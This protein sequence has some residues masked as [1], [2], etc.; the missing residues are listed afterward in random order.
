MRDCGNQD[1]RYQWIKVHGIKSNLFL[2]SSGVLQSGYMSP[3][4]YSLLVNG[5]GHALHNSKLFCFADDLKLFTQIDI[6]R[7]IVLSSRTT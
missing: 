6:H 3:I 7:T 1:Y 4:F 2:A 5:V